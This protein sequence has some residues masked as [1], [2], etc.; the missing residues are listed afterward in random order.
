MNQALPRLAAALLATGCVDKIDKLR[1]HVQIQG[2]APAPATATV[3]AGLSYQSLE[4][5]RASLDLDESLALAQ[6][7]PAFTAALAPA[8]FARIA[9]LT[10]VQI[11][12][13][14]GLLIG[15]KPN[16]VLEFAS[17]SFTPIEG[18]KRR[19]LME[20][21][22]PFVWLA[23][24]MTL[25]ALNQQ[26]PID[27]AVH[28]GDAVD[29]GLKSELAHFLYVAQK[30]RMPF[31]NVAGNHDELAF[32][33][34]NATDAAYLLRINEE[35]DSGDVGPTFLANK[36]GLVL[37]QATHAN[38]LSETAEGLG[39]HSW[40]L[41][42]TGSRH[43]GYD[44][45][46]QPED[47]FYSTVVRAPAGDLPG[48]QLVVLETSRDGGGADPEID[49]RQLA[50]LNETLDSAQARQN[51]VVIA[52]H[53]PII[54][55]HRGD[56]SLGVLTELVVSS[57]LQRLRDLLAHYPNVVLYLCGHTHLPEVVEVQHEGGSLAFAQID[58]GSLLVYPQEAALI[59]LVLA[60]AEVQIAARKMGPMLAP[61]SALARRV[62]ESRHAAAA[63]G[64]S[65]PRY[66]DWRT[67]SGRKARPTFPVAVPKFA[68]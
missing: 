12:E 25:N 34:W 15:E 17:Q 52:G 58:T 1:L 51:L 40:T 29:I 56:S 49:D 24:A 9:H 55:V 31:L 22:S 21:N 14:R 18:T 65:R 35:V 61:G 53:H 44:L 30:L 59:D 37:S 4:E 63:D 41:A 32:G 20:V 3:T 66:P 6:L 19:A 5:K 46:P 67:Y 26:H 23:M 45:A 11:R 50:W 39:I 48:L 36:D 64:Q 42:K 54:E 33:I 60:A 13:E 43:F 38:V 8:P 57:P 2:D 68:L 62:E 27:F 16:D 7:D 28:T 47:A 10:D